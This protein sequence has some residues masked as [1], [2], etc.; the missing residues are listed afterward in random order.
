MLMAGRPA[1]SQFTWLAVII[2]FDLSFV[3][4]LSFATLCVV[5]L[6]QLSHAAV[7]LSVVATATNN[8]EVVLGLI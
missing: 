1:I 4:F 7:G 5:A 2:P 8:L 3:A 6:L